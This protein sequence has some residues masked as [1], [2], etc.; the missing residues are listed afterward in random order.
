MATFVFGL[1]RMMTMPDVDI[2]EL[3]HRY[4]AGHEIEDGERWIRALLRAKEAPVL[5]IISF[6]IQ[7]GR[8]FETL[9]KEMDCVGDMIRRALVE[10]VTPDDMAEFLE[11]S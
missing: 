3:E 7:A 10:P 9:D 1:R 6:C 4:R 11:G 2:R 8:V 5:R